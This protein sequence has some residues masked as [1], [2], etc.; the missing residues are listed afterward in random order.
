MFKNVLHR[1]DIY[2]TYDKRD[3]FFIYSLKVYQAD[4]TKR[5]TGN[6]IWFLYL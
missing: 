1:N 2:L 5:G 3:S 6:Y 4:S